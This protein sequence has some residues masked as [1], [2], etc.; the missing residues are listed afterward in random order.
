MK[1]KRLYVLATAAMLALAAGC[2][3]NPGEGAPENQVTETVSPTEAPE[4]TATPEPTATPAPTATPVPANYMEANGIEVLGAGWHSYTG[5]IS[6]ELDE[7][8]NRILDLGEYECSFEVKEE[9]NGDGTKT[10]EATLNVIPYVYEDGVWVYAVMGGFVD[11]QSGKAFTPMAAEMEQST[12]LKQGE[13]SYELRISYSVQKASSTY[14]YY[15]QRYTL[16]C[17][18]DYED[19]GFYLTGFDMTDEPYSERMGLWKVLSFIR[20]G[21]SE[22]LVFGVNEALA[23]EPEKRPVDGAELAVENYF[24]ANGLSTMGEGEYTWQGIE[25]LRR[26]N[27]ETGEVE[28]VSVEEKE[29]KG[30]FAVEEAS[31]GDGTKQ[32]KGT[33]TY[34][35]EM[36]SAEEAKTPLIKSGIVD[37]KTGLVYPPQTYN[38]AERYVVE[39]DGEEFFISVGAEIS[40]EDMG[41]GKIRT[42]LS[43]VLICPEDYGDAVFFQTGKY[44]TAEDSTHDEAEENMRDKIRVYSL[45]DFDHG[46][47]DLLFFR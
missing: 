37:K 14:P 1:H 36:L 34:M 8:G 31:L 3:N 17:P 24:E 18:S 42:S 39:K 11:L 41:D 5:Y 29:M 40:E 43:F 38:V 21:D 20:H 44:E 32:I 10:I 46:E 15:T 16:V 7:A 2:G 9:D 30:S 22:L 26:L 12:A 27:T 4:A 35:V 45:N 33:F 28:T 13:K 23:T 19:A 25:E 6:R 47:T